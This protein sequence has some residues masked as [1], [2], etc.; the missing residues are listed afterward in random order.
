MAWLITTCCTT[1]YARGM[2]IIIVAERTSSARG[3]LNDG[4]LRACGSTSEKRSF[5]NKPT[6][7]VTPTARSVR[8]CFSGTTGCR[9][10]SPSPKH[11]KSSYLS[12]L[13]PA[14]FW[15][16]FLHSMYGLPILITNYI[17]V[18][19]PYSLL[20]SV[21]TSFHS[22]SHFL[23]SVPVGHAAPAAHLAWH[24]MHTHTSPRSVMCGTPFIMASEL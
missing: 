18:H 16:L 5:M 6:P 3:V 8:R 21:D 12:H 7:L 19:S 13:L 14:H 11:R 1:R 2:V 10:A 4:R 20:S 24:L 22:L 15:C 9:G 17:P 23:H